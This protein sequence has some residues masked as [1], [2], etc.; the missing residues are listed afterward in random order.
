MISQQCTSDRV[1]TRHISFW[2]RNS[3]LGKKAIHSDLQDIS[4]ES[5]VTPHDHR[6]ISVATVK[7]VS[8]MSRL[9]YV[10]HPDGGG[11]LS[12]YFSAGGYGPALAT[13]T[14]G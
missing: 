5:N 12:T 9:V 1:K 10:H 4:Q 13:L 7:N 8:V 3:S 14:L 6:H 11:R 2:E